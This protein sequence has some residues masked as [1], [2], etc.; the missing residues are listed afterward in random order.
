[1]LFLVIKNIG[2]KC[3]YIA[4]FIS[5][6]RLCV[7]VSSSLHVYVNHI[8]V[9][10]FIEYVCL[11]LVFLATEGNRSKIWTT[12]I[13]SASTHLYVCVFASLFVCLLVCLI[14]CVRK[15]VA[16][17]YMCAPQCINMFVWWFIR[18]FFYRVHTIMIV[19]CFWPMYKRKKKSINKSFRG[20][21]IDFCDAITTA[22]HERSSKYT[23]KIS[24][25]E[26]TLQTFPMCCELENN[27][28]YQKLNE[29]TY[30]EWK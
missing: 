20:K 24:Y 11:L 16:V 26:R 18:V 10:S 5:V 25:V 23:N 27:A 12:N 14:L 30:E 8:L 29:W 22:S 13:P 28:N 7:C 21:H 17:T 6:R 9:I 19:L 15:L 1:M 4:Y 3:N 2:L